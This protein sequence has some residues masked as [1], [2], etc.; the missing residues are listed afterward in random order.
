MVI[1]FMG[2]RVGGSTEAQEAP[3]GKRRDQVCRDQVRDQGPEEHWSRASVRRAPAGSG[4]RKISGTGA[5]MIETRAGIA[6]LWR[7]AGVFPVKA[8]K[9]GAMKRYEMPP[10]DLERDPV[11][12]LL[13][14]SPAPRAGGSFVADVLRSV[15]LAAP[16]PAAWWQRWFS[17]WTLG[18]L[19]S[20]AA[21]VALALWLW[22][23]P[24][25]GSAGGGPVAQN[26]EGFSD[27]QQALAEEEMLV[28]AADHLSEFSDAELVVLLGF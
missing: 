6:Q 2:T 16:A 28:A 27:Q 13:A 10:D 24:T 4:G 12:S 25:G 15:H 3:R 23:P 22:S 11:W 19:A 9:Q 18:G 20:T 17:P 8:R 26:H 7:C 14:R 5:E 1:S 21:G